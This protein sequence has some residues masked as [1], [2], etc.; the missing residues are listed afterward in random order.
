MPVC[1]LGMHRSLLWRIVARLQRLRR[2]GVKD[3]V[4]RLFK[5]GQSPIR[6]FLDRPAPDSVILLS[7]PLCVYGWAFS[8]AGPVERVEAFIGEERLGT[9]AYGA[10]VAAAFP[11]IKFSGHSGFE[12]SF[13]WNDTRPGYYELVLRVTDMAGN[14]QSVRRPIVFSVSTELFTRQE[15][16][17]AVYA[18][19]KRYIKVDQARWRNGYLEVEGW[20]LWPHSEPPLLV[21]VRRGQQRVGTVRCNLARPDISEHLPENLRPYCRGFRFSEPLSPAARGTRKKVSFVIEAVDKKGATLSRDIALRYEEEPHRREGG[22]IDHALKAF[23][24]EYQSRTGRQPSILDWNTGLHLKQRFPEIVIVTPPV[25]DQQPLLPYIDKSIDVVFSASSE[26]AFM[27]EAGRIAVGA[28]LTVNKEPEGSGAP[29]VVVWQPEVE[30]VNTVLSAS[31]VIPA[32]NQ[33]RYTRDCLEQLR[34]TLPDSF[35]GEV[36]V[37]DDGSTDFTPAMLAALAQDWPVLKVLRNRQ[38]FGFIDSCN[39]GAQAATGAFLIFLNNDTLPQPGWF[40]PLLQ[41]FERYADAGAVGGKLIYPDGTL[42]EAG[43][44]IFSDGSGWNFG[45]NDSAIDHP[46]YNHVREVDYCSGALLATRREVFLSLD[47]F[48]TRYQPAYYEDTDYCFKVRQRGLKVY[49]QPESV[50][51]HFEGISSGT[52]ITSGIKQYQAINKQKFVDKWQ[53]A[54][55][56]QMPPP[57]EVN[58]GTP[59]R[60]VVR[61]E[62]EEG[63]RYAY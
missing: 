21:H 17:Q 36:I 34:R 1:I 47:G 40:L 57:M 30:V 4:S 62:V 8:S 60:L 2:R 15:K 54:L 11:N 33:G 26:P 7:E 37:V 14:S 55:K 38:N 9:V 49:Y 50:V 63:E 5:R 32:F 59:Y 13:A 10:D 6:I 28:L 20:V 53:Q 31:I 12:Q 41:L 58:R 61:E 22:E 56:R 52:D 3:S 24:T 45:R 39:R 43:G 51:I 29:I 48:D 44:I 25:P 18:S 19:K 35:N 23:M 27:A 16:M 42:Q 46:L